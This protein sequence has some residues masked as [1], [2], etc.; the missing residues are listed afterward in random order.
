MAPRVP[1]ARTES[2]GPVCGRVSPVVSA[3]DRVVVPP[4][5]A[6]TSSSSEG[7]GLLPGVQVVVVPIAL[8]VSTPAVKVTLPLFLGV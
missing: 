4:P 8:M 5:G 6:V 2:V 3:P 7:P 1:K